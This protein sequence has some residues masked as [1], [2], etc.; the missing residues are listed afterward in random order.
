A[1]EQRAD[2]GLDRAGAERRTPE[3]DG[4][5][6][7][8][9]DEDTRHGASSVNWIGRTRIDDVTWNACTLSVVLVIAPFASRMNRSASD[10]MSEG[11]TPGRRSTLTTTLSGV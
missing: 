4:E 3:H 10:V 9:P 11:A 6:E 1:R 7:P 8:W 5:H 2:V